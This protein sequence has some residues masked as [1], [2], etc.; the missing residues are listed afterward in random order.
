MYAR[1]FMKDILY[2]QTQLYRFVIDLEKEIV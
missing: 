1:F 2:K